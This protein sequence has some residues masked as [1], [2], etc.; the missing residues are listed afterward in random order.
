VER[1][2][3]SALVFFGV[4]AIATHALLGSSDNAVY[5]AI[6]VGC[7]VATFAAAARFRPENVRVWL[8]LGV[9]EGLFAGG[10]VAYAHQSA[11]YP[12]V[13][14]ALY[15]L[16]YV[17][18]IAAIVGFLRRERLTRDIGIHIDAVVV[19]GS[20]GLALW[21]LF[22]DDQ[23][24]GVSLLSQAV[25]LAYPI[26]DLI[27]LALLV[28][29]LFEPLR[30][31][32]AF[33][34]LLVSVAVMPLADAAYVVPSVDSETYGIWM[35]IL[36]LASYVALAAAALHR[37]RGGLTRA[38]RPYDE[39]TVTVRRFYVLGAAIAT[40]P[41]AALI[42]DVWRGT[43]DVTVVCVASLA[44]VGVVTFRIV[45]ILRQ[46]FVVRDQLVESERRFRMV[47]ERSPIGISV[48]RD[49][50]MSET[51]P[52]LQRMLGYTQEEL[53]LVHY[54][55]VTHPDDRL[56]DMQTEL[57]AGEREAFS[58]DK[59]YVTK[60]GRAIEAHVHVAL[61]GANGLGISLIEDV[62]ER[63]ALEEQLRQSQKMEAIGKLAG[64]IAHDFNNLMTA[65]L[66]YSDLLLARIEPDDAKRGKIEG[67]R[68]AAVR[69]S[70][71][72]RQLLAF[73][74]RQMLQTTD[75]DLRDVVGRMDALLQRL[76]GE[77]IELVTTFGAAPVVVRA[78]PVQI[79]QVVMNLAVNAR[80][81]MPLGGTLT[82]AAFD[83]GSD[84]ILSVADTGSGIDEA[85]R[86]RIFEPFFTTKP[87]GAGSG[88][89]LS[90]VDGIVGQS[91]GTIEV[92]SEV[93]RGT[94][95]VVRLPLLA[96]SAE[97][98]PEPLVAATLVD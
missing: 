82:I 46:L 95:F 41:A 35:D 5:D 17:A 93:A 43:V 12:N 29:V 21:T 59:R 84:A 8:V 88:L 53:A 69:A 40:V 11:A 14:D 47:F 58:M 6:G 87:V 19:V 30:R 64:G 83:D 81:A 15:L 72:T 49:G 36:W 38:E 90:T 65:V 23:L 85:T 37:S 66:G 1:S 89:G 92:D 91:G 86:G 7:T 45:L 75:V 73:S 34:W 78:D 44:I 39:A 32:P 79:E 57:D 27:L 51:N 48:G 67:I 25:S 10:D 60:D 71:L 28:R 26:G 97:V 94:V 70:D 56:L 4:L 54:A 13:A 62:T 61:D 16:G 24:A 52:A 2:A 80:D 76:I 74:R 50:I 22:V 33:W 9:A 55:D 18:W 31:T 98:L 96:S 3:A 77:Q 68:D 42:S 20:A 63:R